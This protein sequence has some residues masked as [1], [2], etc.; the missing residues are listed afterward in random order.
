MIKSKQAGVW[1]VRRVIVL[2]AKT[3]IDRILQDTQGGGMINT[4][5]IERLNATIRQRLRLFVGRRG[6]QWVQR[7]PALAAGLTDHH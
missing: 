3:L 6:F 1:N 2:G 5:Y 7:T 4:A